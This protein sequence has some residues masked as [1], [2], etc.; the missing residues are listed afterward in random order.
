MKRK[1]PILRNLLRWD[2]RESRLVHDTIVEVHSLLNRKRLKGYMVGG[3]VRDLLIGRQSAD[4]DIVVEG[5]R[6][7]EVAGHLH[8][9][10]GFCK[11]VVYRR[12][13]TVLVARSGVRIEIC[14]LESSLKEDAARR[15][16]TLNCLYANIGEA[17]SASKCRI[18][19]PTRGGMS[20]LAE[21]TLRAPAAPAVTL[22]LDPVRMLRAVRFHASHGFAL[23]PNLRDCIQRMVYLLGRIPCERVRTELEKTLLSRR[24][25][26]S[27][28]LMHRL[29][30]IDVVIP[31]LSQAY[32]FCQSTPFHAHDLFIH[33]IKTAAYAPPVLRLRLA[34]LLHDL[35]KMHT[36]AEAGDRAVYY[37]HQKVSADIARTVLARFRF[38]KRLTNDVVFLIDRHMINYSK[39]WTDKGVRRFVR[40]MGNHLE[41]ML[42]LVE[43]DRKAQ[44]PEKGIAG[45]IV[46][47]R[48]RIRDL[49]EHD[50]IHLKLPVDGNSI[51]EILGIRQGPAVG[52]AKEFLIDKAAG[53]SRS[54]TRSD[55]ERLLRSWADRHDL[56]GVIAVDKRGGA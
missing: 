45:N 52:Q 3:F 44:R 2:S 21:G 6:P 7:E 27:L 19:D 11:P 38:S 53:R 18:L 31:E 56:S 25:T 17:V 24:L 39:T 4:L 13:R 23:E 48:R 14:R 29:G 26:G 32:G 9:R 50:R 47:L 16:F 20:D 1:I 33:S 10:L 12:F 41:D 35:G 30:I 22:W 28:R 36:R 54:L 15:D 55:C 37:G 40:K 5:I 51:M 42:C 34:G 43:S 8:R 46:E 49:V